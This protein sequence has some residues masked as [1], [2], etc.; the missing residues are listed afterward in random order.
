M[1]IPIIVGIASL[2]VWARKE[3]GGVSVIS[4]A[5]SSFD[6]S[7]SKAMSVIRFLESKNDYRSNPHNPNSTASGAYQFLDTTWGNYGGYERAYQAP[8]YVQ[9]ERARAMV[10]RILENHGYDF[11]WVPA[12]WYAG[13]SGAA[14]IDWN[15][16]PS[17]YAGNKSSIRQYVDKWMKLFWRL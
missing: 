7:V 9:D 15:S 3:G 17:S 1:W 14:K 11:K 12:V 6:K 4:P 16:I 8:P 5:N 13:S 2:I 10:V